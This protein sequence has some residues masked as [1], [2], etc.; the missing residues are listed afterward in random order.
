MKNLIIALSVIFS[1]GAFAADLQCVGKT[2][3]KAVR[4]FT[5]SDFFHKTHSR[6]LD[7]YLLDGKQFTKTTVKYF[8]TNECDNGFDF[9]F[10]VADW[11]ELANGERETIKGTVNYEYP[12]RIGEKDLMKG[13]ATISCRIVR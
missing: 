3:A 2:T 9:S 8:I 1:L 12:G 6:D 11:R 10:P 7:G 13:K 5:L 4:T